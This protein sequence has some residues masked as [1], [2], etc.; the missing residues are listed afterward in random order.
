VLIR[1]ALHVHSSLS[2]D[3]TL[4]IAELAQWYR[5]HDYQFIALGE[6]SQ[7]MDQVKLRAL[8]EQS[9][10]NSSSGFCIVPGIEFACKGRVHILGIGITSLLDVFDA[11]AVTEAI[12]Q[13]NGYAVLAHPKRNE[14]KCPPQLVRVV[15]AAEIW[16]VAYDGKLLPSP[17][18]VIGFPR[19][20]QINPRLFA[21]AGHDFHRRGGFYDVAIELD[22]SSLS[23]PSIL[24]G[25]RL[26]RY[27]IR[28]RLFSCTAE[29]D[30]SW[31]QSAL[32]RCLGWQIIKLREARDL[33]LRLPFAKVHHTPY[34]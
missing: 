15:D 31:I 30:F 28:A 17:Q 24:E 25:L 3:G 32:L 14:W 13:L 23:A 12:H 34:H 22:V 4:S 2:H 21:V 7:D 8:V 6:H 29:A 18:S 10:E 27:R 26:G 9:A 33:F 5:A 11:V 19:L 1:G 20:R 16:N